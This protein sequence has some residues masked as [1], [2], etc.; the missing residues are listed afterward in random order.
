MFISPKIIRFLLSSL[1]VMGLLFSQASGRTFTST[2]GT[3]IEAELIHVDPLERATIRREDGRLF[4]DVP[5]EFFSVEDR[6]YIRDWQAQRKKEQDNANL[7]PDAEI[8]VLVGTGRDDDFNEYGDI[9][10]RIVTYQPKVTLINEE[11]LLTYSDVKGTLMLI[12]EHVLSKKSLGVIFRETF[13]L[14]LPP[15]EKTEWYG[16]KFMSR[17]D[18]DCCGF[19][20]EG[21]VLV[22]R[23]QEGKIVQTK[24]SK[25]IWEDQV[26]SILKAKLN[27]TYDR[28]FESEIPSFY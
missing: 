3:Q 17:Y 16:K 19:R 7:T 12:G 24:S 1:G 13:T 6:N 9:D 8:R 2:T 11:M 15:G 25:R 28:K 20:Y 18:P 23:D 26:K 4:R 14:D 10:D 27:K 21:Y 22:L 5:L